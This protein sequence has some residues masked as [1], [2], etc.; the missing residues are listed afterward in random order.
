MKQLAALIVMTLATSVSAH[1]QNTPGSVVPG[2]VP[3]DMR[4]LATGLEGP[5]ELT[6]G[7]H[8][9]LWVTERTGGRITE[10]DPDTGS[11]RTLIELEEVS[12]PGGQDGLLGLALDPG[13][14]EGG[15]GYAYTAYT[16]V[17]AARGADPAVSNAA[18][19]YRF[20]YAK[21]VRLRY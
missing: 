11:K 4:V 3:F 1:A 17:D 8:G 12:A 9:K 21:I 14:L 18:S 5:W 15:N 2:T 10:I 19:P 16:Y 13:L 6:W 7:P 20:L